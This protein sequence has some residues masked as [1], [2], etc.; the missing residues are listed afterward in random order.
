[1]ASR[2]AATQNDEPA[3]LKCDVTT[4]RESDSRFDDVHDHERVEDGREI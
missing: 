3:T 1:M 2:V 4:G